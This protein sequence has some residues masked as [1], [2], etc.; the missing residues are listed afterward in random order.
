MEIVRGSTYQ[1][2]SLSSPRLY[3]WWAHPLSNKKVK[4]VSTSLLPLTISGSVTVRA[5]NKLDIQVLQ[6]AVDRSADVIQ[7]HR[8]SGF[9]F[10]PPDIT[11]SLCHAENFE[12]EESITVEWL[13]INGFVKTGRQE[14]E[15]AN[16]I[17][18]LAE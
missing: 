11:M 18:E 4:V 5:D 12:A 2:K 17:V 13:M 14:V 9:S 16:P 1:I 10:T 7:P 3:N 6:D 15:V 8:L